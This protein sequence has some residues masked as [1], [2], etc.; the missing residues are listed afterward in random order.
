MK[1]RSDSDSAAGFRDDGA[2]LAHSLSHGQ[3]SLLVLWNKLVTQDQIQN[4]NIRSHF[5]TIIWF[6]MTKCW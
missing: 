3:L 4:G 5:E 1:W 2:K 6:W